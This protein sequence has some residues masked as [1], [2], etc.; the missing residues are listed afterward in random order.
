MGL[1][2]AESAAFIRNETAQFKTLIDRTGI[3]VD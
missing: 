2:P 3:R 1:N